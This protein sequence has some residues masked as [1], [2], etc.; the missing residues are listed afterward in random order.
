L[1]PGV[2][3]SRPRVV[4]DTRYG[5][6]KVEGECYDFDVDGR[7]EVHTLEGS[8]TDHERCLVELSG[9]VLKSISCESGGD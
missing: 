4:R 7:S 6:L 9:G 8:D 2:D 5:G 3:P 1:R